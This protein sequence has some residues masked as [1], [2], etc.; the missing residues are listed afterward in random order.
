MHAW[1][2][3]HLLCGGEA[4]VRLLLHLLL[5]L[6]LDR[7]FLLLLAAHLAQAPQ[8]LAR[9][10]R[11]RRHVRKPLAQWCERP[12]VGAVSTRPGE[13]PLDGRHLLLVAL[14]QLRHSVAE[15]GHAGHGRRC[16]LGL[17]ALAAH[18]SQ[19]VERRLLRRGVAPA[20]AR[21]GGECLDGGA[22]VVLPAHG[23]VNALLQRLDRLTVG[24]LSRC[25]L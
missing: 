20:T 18:G 11:V 22:E 23:G 14:E 13:I 25:A 16:G 2:R 4:V 5:L 6:P 1:C 3:T 17:S 19:D 21:L 10:A 8:L 15:R 12:S 7:H 24:R 9:R